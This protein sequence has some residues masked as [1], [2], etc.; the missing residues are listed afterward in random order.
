MENTKFITATIDKRDKIKKEVLTPVLEWTGRILE[1]I[2]IMNRAFFAENKYKFSVCLAPIY[3]K[4]PKWLTLVEFVEFFKLQVKAYIYRQGN[5][6]NQMLV[7]EFSSRLLIK[8][9]CFCRRQFNCVFEPNESLDNKSQKNKFFIIISSLQTCILNFLVTNNE[10]YWTC[11][12][13]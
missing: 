7:S 9:K 12:I 11:F 1:Q 2:I 3:G 8:F 4:D 5:G 6:N 13:F 10:N